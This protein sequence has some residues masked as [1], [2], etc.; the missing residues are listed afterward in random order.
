L[1]PS[2]RVR[3]GPVSALRPASPSSPLRPSSRLRPVSA[4]RPASPSSRLAFV[5]LGSLGREPPRS[6]LSTFPEVVASVVFALQG[7]FLMT[8][9]WISRIIRGGTRERRPYRMALRVEALEHRWCPAVTANVQ[10]GVLLI[11]GD[12]Q[13]DNVQVATKATGEI[14]VSADNGGFLQ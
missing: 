6:V 4:L 9:S 1:G 10:E 12:I 8:R 3:L 7:V 5:P 2:A 13:S 14:T 11:T